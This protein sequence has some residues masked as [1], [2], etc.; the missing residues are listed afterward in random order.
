MA[1]SVREGP[2]DGGRGLLARRGPLSWPRLPPTTAAMGRLRCSDR[3]RP[4]RAAFTSV[5][6]VTFGQDHD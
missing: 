2:V 1:T 4:F 5:W 3:K 6:T